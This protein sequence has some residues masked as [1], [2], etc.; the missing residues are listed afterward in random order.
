[1]ASILRLSPLGRLA[2]RGIVTQER[3]LADV[4]MPGL[5]AAGQGQVVES[6]QLLHRDQRLI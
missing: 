5:Q 1:L 3:D 6:A 2:P 4:G